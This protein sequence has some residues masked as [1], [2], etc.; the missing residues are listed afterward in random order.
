MDQ[1]T[2][3]TKKFVVR[4]SI[5]VWFE[6]DLSLIQFEISSFWNKS[7]QFGLNLIQIKFKHDIIHSKLI[8]ELFRFE[9]QIMQ[10]MD[11]TISSL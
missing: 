8:S 1:S 6:F 7:N 5:W 3:V 10:L 2:W 9:S 4:D 11:S